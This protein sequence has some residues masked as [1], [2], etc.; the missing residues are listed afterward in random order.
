M[1]RRTPLLLLSLSIALALV[2]TSGCGPQTAESA[3][4]RYQ[5][6]KDSLDVLKTKMPSMKTSIDEKLVAFDKEFQEAVAKGGEAG[7]AAMTSIARRVE[8]FEKKLNPQKATTATPAKSAGSKLK[9]PA[10]PA[11]PGGKLAAPAAAAP[12]PAGGKLGQPAAAPAPG[13]KLGGTA[14]PAPKPA[15]APAAKPAPAPAQPKGGSGFGGK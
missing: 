14:A 1:L 13:G 4:A 9:T 11:A 10:A 8:D 2:L 3:T 7:V 6:A 5:R 12:A 15:A